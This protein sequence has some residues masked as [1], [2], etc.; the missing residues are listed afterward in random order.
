MKSK[1]YIDVDHDNHPVIRVEH[2]HSEDVRDKL[3][4]KFLESFSHAS[5]WCRTFDQPIDH[6]PL[7]NIIG[8]AVVASYPSRITLIRPVHPSE[9][10]RLSEESKEMGE[11]W[12]EIK[13][14]L[15]K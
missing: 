10:P 12:E 8:S 5:V 3:I 15:P 11:Y 4:A 9:L 7:T 13:T 6:P 14:K 2:H 1:I